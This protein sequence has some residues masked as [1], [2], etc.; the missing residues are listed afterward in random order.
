MRVLVTGG[1]GFVGSHFCE[2]LLADGHEVFCLDNLS[3]GQVANIAHLGNQRGFEFLEQDACEEIRLSGRVDAVAHLASPA[4]PMDY[5]RLPIQTLRAGSVGTQRTLDLAHAKDARFLL[6]STSEVY[7]DPDVHPQ[8]EGYWGHVNPI[9]PRSVYD[10]AKRFAEAITSAY[11]RAHGLDTRIARIF[12]TY[13]PRMRPND[14]RVVSAFVVQALRNDPITIFG[15]GSQTRSFCYV[16]DLVEGLRRLLLRSADGEDVHAPVNLGGAGE[17]TVRDL[18]D[19]VIRVTGSPSRIEFKPLPADDP[20]MRRPD[21]A[22]A[23][24]LLDWEAKVRLESGLEETIRYFLPATR[25]PSRTPA[26]VT[27]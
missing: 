13:G 15:D 22:R 3:T 8:P 17:L 27:P 20:K 5:L 16:L 25:F 2:R 19:T 4:S 1:A 14:G 21:L 12:N 18:A 26:A 10:E 24:D 9:G 7:G 6:A 23:R 11:R